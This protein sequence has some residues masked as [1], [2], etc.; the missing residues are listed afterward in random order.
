VPTVSLNYVFARM[1][2]TIKTLSFWIKCEL[3][4][5]SRIPKDYTDQTRSLAEISKE[6]KQVLTKLNVMIIGL[7]IW[8]Q[9]KGLGSL[10]QLTLE[11]IKQFS[12]KPIN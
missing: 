8:V 4:S 7:S 6:I 10:Y 2:K 11:I 9:S 3:L 1:S 5:L 12:K